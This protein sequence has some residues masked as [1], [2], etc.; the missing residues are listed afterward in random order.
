M[1]ETIQQARYTSEDV[2][3]IEVIGLRVTYNDVF[4]NEK[5]APENMTEQEKRIFNKLKNG[6]K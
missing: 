6:V 4:D 2:Y 1:D 5:I 3:A